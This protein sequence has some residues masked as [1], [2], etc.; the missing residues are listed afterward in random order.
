[1]WISSSSPDLIT[2]TKRWKTWNRCSR[3]LLDFL[4]SFFSSTLIDET[5]IQFKRME[6]FGY[7]F[8]KLLK[9]F[10]FYPSHRLLLLLTIT[11]KRFD[12]KCSEFR[13]NDNHTWYWRFI[14]FIALRKTLPIYSKHYWVTPA[15][16]WIERIGLAIESSNG[17]ICKNYFFIHFLARICYLK[18]LIG[19]FLF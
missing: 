13:L 3:K 6:D 8:Q 11:G 18:I 1:M 10:Y 16:S 5:N 4:F 12:D 9:A 19:K 15:K 2:D 7:T 17:D 14:L